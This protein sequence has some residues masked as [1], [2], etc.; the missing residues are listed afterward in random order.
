ML[1][2]VGKEGLE[3]I[4]NSSSPT[5]LLFYAKWCPFPRAFKEIFG[6]YA[7]RSN[8]DFCLVDLSDE[9]NPL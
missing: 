5:V 8:V 6:E 2:E 7:T 9:E 3:E 4:L 1:Y